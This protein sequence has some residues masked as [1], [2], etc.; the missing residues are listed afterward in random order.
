V[1]HNEPEFTIGV[2]EEYLL[3]DKETRSL[4]VDPPASLLG[5]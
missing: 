5:E 4:V 3:V 1:T 2:E